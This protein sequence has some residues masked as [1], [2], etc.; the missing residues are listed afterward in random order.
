MHRPKPENNPPPQ[1][2]WQFWVNGSS[3]PYDL[4]RQIKQNQEHEQQVYRENRLA[5]HITP[6]LLDQAV[7][8]IRVARISHIA[9]SGES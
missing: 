9:S 6:H 5:K 3:D 2:L 4:A 1:P 8:L 7:S